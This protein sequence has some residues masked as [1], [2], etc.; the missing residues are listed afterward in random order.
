MIEPDGKGAHL[1]ER[2]IKIGEQN[3]RSAWDVWTG[4]IE[5]EFSAAAH[6]FGYKYV[7]AWLWTILKP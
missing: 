2:A 3:G 7:C 5:K 6:W 4:D 1:L